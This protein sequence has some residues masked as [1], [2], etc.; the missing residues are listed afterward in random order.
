MTPDD[1]LRA[2]YERFHDPLAAQAL[3]DWYRGSY[4]RRI[5]DNVGIKYFITI[6]HSIVPPQFGDTGS[7]YV[8]TAENQF[9]RGGMVMNIELLDGAESIEQIE[10]FFAELWCNLHLDYYEQDN[11]RCC[12]QSVT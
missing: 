12:P 1:L 2:G 5:T 3:G 9:T 8:F 4:Q 10:E 6:R 11:A 7:R